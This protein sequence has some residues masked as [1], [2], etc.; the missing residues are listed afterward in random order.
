M[1]TVYFTI[2]SVTRELAPQIR[3]YLTNILNINWWPGLTIISR[4]QT[5]FKINLVYQ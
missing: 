5:Y 4:S 1:T 3:T 2:D